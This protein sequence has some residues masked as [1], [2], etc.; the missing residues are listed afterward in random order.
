MT[1]C[2]LYA[3]LINRYSKRR[4]KNCCE[5]NKGKIIEPVIIKGFPREQDLK[6][7]ER[8]ADEILNKHKENK[9]F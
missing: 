7:L 3:E 1:G 9:I 2:A 5:R 6:A 8:L 4:T